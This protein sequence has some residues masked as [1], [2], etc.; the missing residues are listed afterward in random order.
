MSSQELYRPSNEAYKSE[1]ETFMALPMRRN[2][3]Q[4]RTSK[5]LVS[6]ESYCPSKEP[7]SPANEAYTLVKEDIDGS[8]Y[9][10][11]QTSE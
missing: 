1:R 6:K 7:Y 2:C 4:N 5:H 10:W 11:Y 3:H 9:V 8:S